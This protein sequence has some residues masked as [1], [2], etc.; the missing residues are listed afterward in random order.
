MVR[1]W[2]YDVVEE[3]D[4]L[5]VAYHR[6]SVEALNRAA[7]EVWEKLGKLS[8][9]ELE[10]PGGRRY[11]AGDRVITLAPGPGGAWVTSQRAVVASV[12]PR[13]QSLVA[14]TPEG[15]VLQMGPEEI[16]SGKLMHAYAITAHRSQGSTV[17]VTSKTGA[18]VSWPTWR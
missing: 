3:R 16:G 14:L 2:S 1:A 6:D 17:D 12:D 18:D 11:R 7:R 8:G 9:P 15:A 10:A 5:L 4:A 13:T